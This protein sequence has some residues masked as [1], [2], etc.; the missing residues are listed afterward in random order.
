MNPTEEQQAIILHMKDP[1]NKN[2]VMAAP[3][4]G[5]TTTLAYGVADIDYKFVAITFTNKAAKEL[6]SRLTGNNAVFIGTFHG[7]GL[8]LLKNNKQEFEIIDQNESTELIRSCIKKMGYSPDSDIYKLLLEAAKIKLQN[9]VEVNN[10]SVQDSLDSL[11][12]IYKTT[13]LKNHVKDFSDLLYDSIEY[14]RDVGCDGIIVDEWQ[15]TNTVQYNMVKELTYDF[16]RG[17][18]VVGDQNQC[19]YQFRGACYENTEMLIKESGAKVLPLSYTWRFDN[20]IAGYC[21]KLISCN[22]DTYSSEITAEEASIPNVDFYPFNSE[23]DENQF[24]ARDIQ[25]YMEAGNSVAILGRTH[26]QLDTV[27][28]YFDQ[29]AIPYTRIGGLSLSER[30]KTKRL[31]D[32]ICGLHPINKEDGINIERTSQFLAY[33]KRGLGKRFLNQF[34]N[35]ENSQEK[36]KI[37]V[38]NEDIVEIIDKIL[39]NDMQGVKDACKLLDEMDESKYQISLY[40]IIDYMSD[41]CDSM[42]DLVNKIKLTSNSD[43]DAGDVTIATVHGVKGLEFDIVYMCGME[44]GYYPCTMVEEDEIESERRVVYVAMSRAKKK[45]NI[46]WSYRRKAGAYNS[47]QPRRASRFIKEMGYSPKPKSLNISSARNWKL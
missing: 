3:G 7:L 10:L 11:A 41:S 46:S 13:K 45:L 39:N 24:L 32:L 15:D 42:I 19:L 4:S 28:I 9:N 34:I 44:E 21:N 14:M 38:D 33:L 2:V 17:F 37:L 1:A 18:T 40:E 23:S 30:G 29:R 25:R 16:N 5:K 36:S 26:R 12:K 31:I 43:N 27:A 35:R 47:S 22:A 8:Q 20:H 6:T